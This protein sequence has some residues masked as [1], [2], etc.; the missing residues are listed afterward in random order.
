MEND[1]T[2]INVDAVNNAITLFQAAT[3]T[4]EGEELKVSSES[5]FNGLISAG[6]D[7]GF[8]SSYSENNEALKSSL[9][10]FQ[11]AI[12]STIQNMENLDQS[13]LDEIDDL[14]EEKPKRNN[15]N[16]SGNT[17]NNE[18]SQTHKNKYSKS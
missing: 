1:G 5:F 2:K 11:N 16:G 9:A 13:V 10:N 8:V 17:K 12:L 6:L 15:N 7:Q 3:Q 4:L 18:S 14:S